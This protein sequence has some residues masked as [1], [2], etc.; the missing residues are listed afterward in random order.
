MS[1]L[2][3]Y[4]DGFFEAT[5]QGELVGSLTGNATLD[6]ASGNIFTH[7]PSSNVTYVFNNPPAT[8]SGYSFTIK[9]SPSS[10]VSLTWPSSVNWTDGS[11]P[12]APSS[13][14]TSVISLFTTDGGTNYYAFPI[15]SSMS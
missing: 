11:A 5:V 2:I 4:S 14:S 10:S 13:G 3:D 7:S 1:L 8:G 12:T 9:V 6:L 15:G